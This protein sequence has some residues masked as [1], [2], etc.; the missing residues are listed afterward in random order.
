MKRSMLVAIATVLMAGA[1][2]AE[3]RMGGIGFRSLAA[4]GGQPAL[5]I[6]HWLT[7]QL[8]FDAAIG[9]STSSFKQGVPLTT[10]DEVSGVSFDIGVPISAKKWDR[11][12]LLVRPGFTYGT[13]TQKDKTAP[14]PPNE[15]KFKT[16]AVAGEIEVEVMVADKLSVSAAHGV[17]WQSQKFEDNDTPVNQ[18]KSSTFRTLGNNFT[19]FGFHVYLW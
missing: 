6:R 2:H 3:D 7:D 13:E 5:G 15:F 10:T 17:A 9:F 19:S 12:N 16:L 4:A 8:G 1:V 14:T 11:V 18:F